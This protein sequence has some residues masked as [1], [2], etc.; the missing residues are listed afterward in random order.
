MKWTWTWKVAGAEC[1]LR[2]R[3]YTVERWQ[4]D[5][6]GSSPY[7][8]FHRYQEDIPESVLQEMIAALQSEEFT[9]WRSEHESRVRK[10]V[11]AWNLVPVLDDSAVPRTRPLC[12]AS[13]DWNRAQASVKARSDAVVVRSED[14]ASLRVSQWDPLR[15]TTCHGQEIEGPAL[16]M[17]PALA[18][19]N[20][21]FVV[22]TKQAHL[23]LFSS[24]GSPLPSTVD[25]AS[26]HGFGSAIHVMDV[27]VRDDGPWIRFYV[28][29]VDDHLPLAQVLGDEGM[30]KIDGHLR[31]L[32]RGRLR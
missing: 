7:A 8:A 21:F 16:T 28:A 6:G 29:N 22:D 1:G 17:A 19:K 20:V 14:G 24:D 31:F 26:T 32:K 23:H 2:L 12:S 27:T 4:D 30:I 3:V 25:L 9:Q 5:I 15:L 11:E 10:W 13:A 18:W